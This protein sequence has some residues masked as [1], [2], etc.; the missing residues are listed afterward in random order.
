MINEVGCQGRMAVLTLKKKHVEGHWARGICYLP[1]VAAIHSAEHMLAL[2]ANKVTPHTV[3]QTS[4]SQQ[5]NNSALLLSI[6]VVIC[7]L[8]HQIRS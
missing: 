4:K 6:S 2:S 3:A 7:Q 8:E 5:Q 1:C